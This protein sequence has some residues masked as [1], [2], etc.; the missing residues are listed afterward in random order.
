MYSLLL[1]G[2]SS[3]VFALLLT[4]LVRNLAWR[5]GFI[6]HPDQKRKIHAAPTPRM[7]G[8]AIF[9]SVVGAFCLLLGVRLTSGAIVW[10]GLPLVLRLFPALA[11]IF[12]IGLIDDIFTLRPWKKLAAEIVAAILAWSGGI[13][14]CAL[15]G[16]SFSGTVI[17][18]I[19]TVLWIITCTNAINLIDGVDGLAAGVSLFAALTMLIAALLNHNMPMAL[20]VV[21]LVGALW[22]FLRYNFNPASIFLGD[23]G[24]LTLGFLLGC[25]GVVWSEKSTTVLGM[26]APLLVLSVPLFDLGLAVVRRFIRGQPIFRADRAHIHHKLLSRGLTPRRL[27]LVIYSVC[28][29]G[30]VASLLMTVSRESNRGFVI[31][32][33]CLAAWLGLQHLGYNEIG[34]AGRVVLGGVF[35]SALSAQL[36]LEAFENEIRVDITLQQCCDLL[37]CTCSQFGFSGVIFDLDGVKRQWGIATGWQVCIDFPGHGY[38]NLWRAADAQSRGAAAVLFMDCISR[39]F[40]QK[41]SQIKNDSSCMRREACVDEHAIALS[42]VYGDDRNDAY[43]DSPSQ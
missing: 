33:F 17:S 13:H 7:G 9:V 14:I 32:L 41:L 1:L 28:G 20:A 34:V 30:A 19:V 21:P 12:T 3:F 23:C 38:I 2:I 35:R 31:V 10:E 18:F 36:A 8:V 43:L 27:V 42:L 22:G 24:S 40:K 6:D 29:I 16:Y 11:V 26:T 25:F 15:A 37:C 4:P 39:A 5:F